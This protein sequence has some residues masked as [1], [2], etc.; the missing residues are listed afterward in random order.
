MKNIFKIIINSI[1]ILCSSQISAQVGDNST[2]KKNIVAF[3]TSANAYAMDKVGKLPVDMFRGKV[4]I[5]IP[6]YTVN[7]D[8]VNIPVSLSY[9]TGGIKLNEVASVA[10]LGWA[11][12]IPGSIN[13]NIVDKDDKYSSMYTKNINTV[14][15]NI[16]NIGMYDNDF[17]QIV[18]DHYEGVYDTRPDM[19]NY[20]L[21]FGGGSFIFNN[22]TGHTIPHEDLLITA[23]NNKKNIKIV[24]TDG[25]SY[26]LSIKNSTLLDS[27][28][29]GSTS[30]G[31][32]TLY[33]IDSITTPNNK[34]ISF[35]YAKSYSYEEKSITERANIDITKVI[36]PNALFPPPLPDYERYIGYVVNMEKLITKINFPDGAI[37][38]NYSNDGL[39]FSDG[40]NIRKDLAGP[41]GVALRQILVKDNYGKIIKNYQ[42]NFSYFASNTGNDFQNFRLKLSNVYDALQNNYYKFYY[43]E[44]IPFPARNSNNDDYWGYINATTFG[45]N[46]AN[47]PSQIYTD[48]TSENI[49]VK[50]GHTRDR[51]TN[52]TY[53]QIG[54]LN[55]I[56]YP[57]GGSKN[58]Y[59][60]NASKF[61][62][63]TNYQWGYIDNFATVLSE[64]SGGLSDG[65]GNVNQTVNIPSNFLEGKD[66]PKVKLTFGNTCQNNVDDETNQVHDTSC[67]GNAIYNGL[68]YGTN[69]KPAEFEVPVEGTS[70]NVSL[71]RTGKCQCGYS[72]GVIYGKFNT[73]NSN[74]SIGGL[75]IKKIED[76]NENNIVN[77]YN[78]KYE[79]LDTISNTNK[80]SGVLNMPFQYTR[81][82]TRYTMTATNEVELQNGPAVQHYLVVNNSSTNYNTYGSSD[83]IT[84]KQV[85][86]YN[87]LGENIN[88]FSQVNNLDSDRMYSN[89]YSNYDDWK[90]GFLEKNIILNKLKDTLK[91]E[92]NKYAFNYLKNPKAGF[93]TADPNQMG[94]ALNLDIAK[95]PKRVTYDQAGHPIYVQNYLLTKSIIGINSGKVEKI[96]SKTSEYFPGNKVIETVTKS[97]YYDTDINKPINVKTVS[98]KSSD[99]TV[100]ETSY[101][102]AHE[103]GNQLM[104]GKNMVAIPLETS[105]TQTM[106]STTK[107]LSKTE[108]IYPKTT[109]EITNNSSSLVL[110]LS[111]LSYD[112]QTNV[113]STEAT[114]DKYDSRGNIQQ[115]TTR[116]GIS[117]T[118]IWGYNKS[119]PIAKIEGAK[120]SDIA[121]SLIDNI[122]SASDNDAQLGTD[123]SEQSLVAAL[124]LFRNNSALS[125]YQISTYTCDPLIGVRSITPPSGIRELYKYDTA[126]R[127]EKVIDVNGKVLK[128]YQYNYKN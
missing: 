29:P 49:T 83:I 14:Y 50:P 3:P 54:I 48:I 60:E 86:E 46:S 5:N 94:F 18:D 24:S 55:K 82:L 68:N 4:N 35:E 53:T 107:T 73:I 125:G 100:T 80:S 91:V 113:P 45:E 122:V 117:T 106:G 11:L 74:V 47:L 42:L 65:F 76:K 69:G 30:S 17:R 126:N 21:P 15:S 6:F 72:L 79:V 71:S 108:T 88:V 75:R 96:E 34:K 127:L 13:Q 39:P 115:Y 40:T 1:I 102:Y 97:E 85:T 112:L 114:Y 52:P 23:T 33:Q 109:A 25:A 57:T 28:V 111:V 81:L 22:D 99:N 124:D 32:Q 58:L 31:S 92:T 118:V 20:S 119:Q 59:Y 2:Q 95:F 12:N 7:V 103:R 70:I 38:F 26:F 43:D 67:Y 44:S 51:N 116:S 36:N 121:Q 10:G 89:V 64:P 66:S 27:G 87:D 93:I 56:E 77:A 98:V 128:E 84:Y 101:Q 104:I 8:G 61:F 105:T 110:P 41:G 62:K 16:T 120:L 123:A 90:N 63:K 37:Y 19:F 9:N 78:Y